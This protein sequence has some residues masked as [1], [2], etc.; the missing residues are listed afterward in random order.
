VSISV[1]VIH[2]LDWLDATTPEQHAG[3]SIEP[4]GYAVYWNELDNG[5]K[6]A[7]LLAVQ[8]LS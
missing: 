5:I 3:W 1:D 2:W 7:H 4:G 6:T 8:P